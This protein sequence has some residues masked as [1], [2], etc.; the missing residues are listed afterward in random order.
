ML[1]PDPHVSLLY[2]CPRLTRQYHQAPDLFPFLSFPFVYQNSLSCSKNAE[3]RVRWS[4]EK[5]ESCRGP[6]RSPSS[7]HIPSSIR[8]LFRV[9]VYVLPHVSDHAVS[10]LHARVDAF[11][12]NK[13]AESCQRELHSKVGSS[14]GPLRPAPRAWKFALLVLGTIPKAMLV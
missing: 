3:M 4:G 5:I 13:N 8:R 12:G 11:L 14:S 1:R 6:S 7:R 10:F 9:H 2:S